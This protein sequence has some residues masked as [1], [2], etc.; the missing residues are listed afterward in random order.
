MD[1]FDRENFYYGNI[2]SEYFFRK[3]QEKKTIAKIGTLC[4]IALLF[5]VVL[6]LIFTIFLSLGSVIEIYTTNAIFQSAVDT[7]ITLISILLPFSLAGIKM[8]KYAGESELLA[9]N[10]R[11]SKTDMVLAVF[12]GAGLCLIASIISSYFVVLAENFGIELSS[13]EVPMPTGVAGVIIC[14]VRVV[15]AA[16]LA[17]EL[18]LRGYVLGSLR[19]H[20]DNFAIWTA[21]IVFAVM[22]GNLVQAPFALLAGYILGYLAVKTGTLWT[23]ILVHGM[24]NLFSV[25]VSYLLDYGDERTATLIY[26]FLL[27]AV[28]SVGLICFVIFSVRTKHIRLHKSEGFLS[29]GEKFKAFFM[30]VPMVLFLIYMVYAFSLYIN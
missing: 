7:V 15:L 22:H 5:Y 23:A 2:S 29:N 24:N 25:I 20:G 12:S 26:Y 17:E 13:A 19:K 1:N 14:L 28:I 27:V 9:F 21:A 6:Q 11:V 30:N 10:R 16:A 4:G 8:K 18:S 3:Q